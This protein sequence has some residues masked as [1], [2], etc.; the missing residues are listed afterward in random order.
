MLAKRSKLLEN[1]DRRTFYKMT[2]KILSEE[3]KS[4]TG[5]ETL[6]IMRSCRLFRRSLVRKRISKT[7]L[8]LGL[9]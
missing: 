3:E 9:D 5:L 1:M 6:F 2:G 7:V 4:V 8:T